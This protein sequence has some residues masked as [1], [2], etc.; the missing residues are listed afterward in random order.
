MRATQGFTGRRNRLICLRGSLSISWG[1]PRH[2][3]KTRAS[4]ADNIEEAGHLAYVA[5]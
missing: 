3:H 4:S 5:S 2:G 1:E